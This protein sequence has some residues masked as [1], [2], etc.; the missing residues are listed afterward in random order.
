MGA[1]RHPDLG[2]DS[3]QEQFVHL[4]A[5]ARF[6]REREEHDKKY[7]EHVRMR[8]VSELSRKIGQFLDWMLENGYDLND[9]PPE[10]LLAMYFEID[11][12]KISDEKDAMVEELQK[13]AN[14]RTE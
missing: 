9:L 10:K 3:V 13:A 1:D 14:T 11:L 2:D 4:D 7:P 6:A 12:K 5:K 8:A